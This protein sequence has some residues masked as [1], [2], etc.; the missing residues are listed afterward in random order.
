MLA[1]RFWREP[2]LADPGVVDN[3]FN[4]VLGTVGNGSRVTGF[5]PVLDVRETADEYL[6]LVDVPGVKKED[7]SIELNDHELTISGVRTPV[8][9]GEVVRSERPYG[10]FVRSLT[11]PQGVDVEKIVADY[12]AG[13]LALRVPKPAEAKPKKIEIGSAQK[14]LSS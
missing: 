4:R 3:V 8:E 6:V 10:S 9:T 1:T 11:L 13:V 7:V 12:E 2:F 14:A 5:V